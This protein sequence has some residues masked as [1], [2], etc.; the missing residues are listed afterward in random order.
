MPETRAVHPRCHRR[1]SAKIVI[2]E[3]AV[4]NIHR[5]LRV[6]VNP[7]GL[8]P[9]SKLSSK[10]VVHPTPAPWPTARQ[11][12]LSRRDVNP[13][14]PVC[15]LSHRHIQ[16]LPPVLTSK[17]LFDRPSPRR[18]RL[19]TPSGSI[20]QSGRPGRVATHRQR[21]SAWITPSASTSSSIC[22]LLGR[23]G[24]AMIPEERS[25][26]PPQT[27]CSPEDS[28]H[29]A[30]HTANRPSHAI[31]RLVRRYRSQRRRSRPS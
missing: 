3:L 25:S 11:P 10:I 21:P 13:R 2:G 16:Y 18:S 9:V 28:R 19:L 8:P 4:H 5:T 26:A 6:C 14:R 1:S 20:S 31:L 23:T 27:D 29:D 30:L 12:A 17:S 7:F 22:R 15:G 24:L